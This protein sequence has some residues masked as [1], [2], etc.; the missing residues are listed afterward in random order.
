MIEAFLLGVVFVTSVAAGLFFLKFWRKTREPLFL[1]FA[2]AFTVE[3]VNRLGFL[4]LA[5]PNEGSLSI[6]LVRLAAFLL[7]LATILL[8]KR[9]REI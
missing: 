7:I 9:S 1:A 6:Y 2:V 4:F 5:V 3:G 8:R